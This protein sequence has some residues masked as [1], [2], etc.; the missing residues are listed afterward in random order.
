[1]MTSWKLWVALQNPP[2]L[3]PV[4]RRTANVEYHF[5]LCFAAFNRFRRLAVACLSLLT[6]LMVITYPQYALLFILIVPM[7]IFFI[8]L[9]VPILLVIGSNLMGMIW[10]SLVSTSIVR[11]RERGTYDLLCL[12]P[13]GIWGANWAIGSGCIYR[14]AFFDLL[15]LGVRTLALFGF[16][17]LGIMFII[18][19]GIAASSASHDDL[20][21][22]IS[23]L[24]DMTAIMIGY[25]VHYVQSM[26]FSPLTGM[27]TAT[28]SRS[29]FDAR[30]YAPIFFLALQIGSYVL[31]F[32]IA[33][34]ILP[35][36][37]EHFILTNSLAYLTLPFVQLAI[38]YGIR[39]GIL[40]GVWMLVKQELNVRFSEFN[41]LVSLPQ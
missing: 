3:N 41:R 36:I 31:T 21:R 12:L 19:L 7:S 11:E 30:L 33:F 22:A 39:E 8:L 2:A 35:D 26:V 15:Q 20:L 1:M 38:F 27:L 23:T 37:Y 40:L 34:R 29:Q 32:L 9:V 14:G 17:I 13:D 10:S 4:F 18:T 6:V 16:V 5:S 28:Y 25:Y 24:I